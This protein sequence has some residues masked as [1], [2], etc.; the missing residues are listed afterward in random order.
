MSIV[1][2]IHT[3][4]WRPGIGDPTLLGWTTVYLYLCTG[5]LSLA[6]VFWAHRIF[7]DEHTHLHRAIW[8]IVALGLFG[9]ALN[10]QLDLQTLVTEIA[11]AVAYEQGWYAHRRA[12]QVHLLAVMILSGSLGFLVLAWGVRNVWQHYW[13]L[14]LGGVAL[15][16]FV[17]VRAASI[18]GVALP[19]LSRWS[20]GIHINWLLELIG[21][22]IILFAVLMNL[23]RFKG[24]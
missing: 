22:G 14:L 24:Q 5:L 7:R 17:I 23:R 3:V 2:V 20:G 13:L 9:L 6:C 15:G 11:R 8:G 21:A 19:E 16:R 1:D 10:K 18:Y 12:L 4:N